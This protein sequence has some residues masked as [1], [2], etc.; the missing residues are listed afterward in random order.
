MMLAQ[1]VAGC[2]PAVGQQATLRR[3]CTSTDPFWT[4]P[5]AVGPSPPPRR[6]NTGDLPFSLRCLDDALDTV[7]A[8]RREEIE[9]SEDEITSVQITSLEQRLDWRNFLAEAV[10]AS[11]ARQMFTAFDVDPETPRYARPP[12]SA[13]PPVAAGAQPRVA[14]R[15]VAPAGAGWSAGLLRETSDHS[16]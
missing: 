5:K 8:D 7:A 14:S 1:E 10:A 15:C 11:K 2:P 13:P 9:V 16:M 12:P 4:S 6:A 3:R